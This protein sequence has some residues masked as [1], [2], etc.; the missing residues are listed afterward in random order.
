MLEFLA[1]SFAVFALAFVLYILFRMLIEE[2]KP[3]PHEKN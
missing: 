2:S 3:M 1:E